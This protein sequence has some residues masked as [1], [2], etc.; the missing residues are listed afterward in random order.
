MESSVIKTYL[1]DYIFDIMESPK[2]RHLAYPQ[3]VRH[4][5]AGGQ[6]QTSSGRVGPADHSLYMLYDSLT[7]CL[8]KVYA[9][10]CADESLD[11]DRLYAEI[12]D[13]CGEIAS[14]LVS[15][16]K[17]RAGSQTMPEMCYHF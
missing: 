6:A 12:A 14:R 11:D 5:S 15:K 8:S 10:L 17:I 7:L 16:Q 9:T 4:F 13:R 2:F 3:E 1:L